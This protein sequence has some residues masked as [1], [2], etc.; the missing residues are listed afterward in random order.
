MRIR[1]KNFTQLLLDL[2]I[3]ALFI[4]FSL[5]I[6][7]FILK[8]GPTGLFLERSFK[9]V[10]LVFLILFILFIFFFIY[11]KDFS[12][13]KKFDFPQFKDIFLIALPI[14]PIISYAILNNNYLD[15]QGSLYLFGFPLMFIFIFSFILPSI[16]SYFSS[17][18]ILLI[19][20]LALCYTILSLPIITSNP[21]SHFFNSQLVT[22]GIYLIFSFIIMYLL[23][24]F[25]KNLAYIFA[26]V[27]MLAGMTSKLS[28]KYINKD[29]IKSASEE[30]LKMF[31]K[32][33]EN[34]IIDKK[35]VYIIVYESYP[36]FET[37]N[38]YGYDNSKQFNHL[39]KNDFTIYQGSYS[40]GA[41]SLSSIARLFEIKGNLTNH[42]R[43]YTSGNSFGLNIFKANGYTIESLF[44]TPYFFGNYPIT[45][46]KYHPKVNVNKIGGK[47]LIESV[48]K[49]EFR[50]N[51]FDKDYIYD[52]Y[53]KLKNKN[54]SSNKL[55]P[56]L[57]YTHN[58]YPGHS[59]NSGRCSPNEK[60][61]FF[62][63]LEKAN[64]E[65]KNDI[66]TVRQ[67]DPKAII[68]LLGDHGPY[69]TKNCTVLRKFKINLIDKYD[70]QDRYGA[71]LAIRWPDDL[72]I[73][74][75]ELQITQDIFP[76]ILSNITKNKKLFNQLKVDRK[77][78]DRFDT[79]IGGVNISNG[80][81]VGGI[82]DGKPL[83]NIRTYSIK[84][85]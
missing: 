53:L 30:N 69:L 15:F 12:F 47:I 62:K 44:N 73:A 66:K 14:S 77:F 48:Y 74:D 17:L 56:T 31:L 84:D 26:I 25:N 58:S 16:F 59:N 18:N 37:I 82:D 70:V 50:P 20:G 61:K 75:N 81:V 2:T 46:D 68:V 43:Y 28:Y 49:G 76:A 67:S 72:N 83:F 65:M 52:E 39:E 19:S 27:F 1:F 22:Q 29:I 32:N 21:N 41:S 33:D 54:L 8:V 11:N 23:Y 9:L 60:K 10:G 3:N 55:S 34:K 79:N 45:W 5:F 63:N 13:K 4:L 51:A 40:N 7:K 85:K 64:I 78:Y 71:L 80:I 57:F 6:L 38:H 36:N 42:E 24:F 35:N